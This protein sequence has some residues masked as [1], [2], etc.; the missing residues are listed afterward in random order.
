MKLQIFRKNPLTLLDV[1][2][3]PAGTKALVD[4]LE[5][6]FPDKKIIFVFGAMADKDYPSMLKEICRKAKFIVLT[7][8]NYKRAADLE[9]LEEVV[10]KE[11]KPYEILPKVKQAYIFALKNAKTEDVIC[12]TGSHFTVGEFLSQSEKSEVGS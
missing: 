1:A 3:N 5:E 7:K 9:L 6:F 12:I 4:A 2:H 8:P 11:S 10:L